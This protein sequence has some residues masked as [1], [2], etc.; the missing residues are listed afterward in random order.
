M[1]HRTAFGRFLAA[2]QEQ[3]GSF[4]SETK[5]SYQRTTQPSVRTIHR[6]KISG[7]LDNTATRTAQSLGC[8]PITSFFAPTNSFPSQQQPGAEHQVAQP[9][10]EAINTTERNQD[11]G[12]LGK[13]AIRRMET[14]IA[15]KNWTGLMR[16]KAVLQLLYYQQRIYRTGTRERRAEVAR[17]VACC[18]NRGSGFQNK[19]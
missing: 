15:S 11:S 9:E 19:W 17:R 3:K 13:E 6:W 10:P 14:R 12:E 5:F 16:H 1:W 8:K 7:K 4:G 18:Y 2:A